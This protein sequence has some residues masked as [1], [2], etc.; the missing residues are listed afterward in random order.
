MSISSSLNA[1]VMGLNSNSSRLSAISDNIAN[2]ST[3][4]YKRSQ[5]DFSSMVLQQQSSAYAAG[6]VRVS[7]FKDI[8][9]TGSLISTGNATDLA[10]SGRGLV[11]V[12]DNT[13]VNSLSSER[14]LMLL[15]TGSFYADES[16]NL[17][18]QS[19]L[20]LLGWPAN[21]DGEIGNVSRNSGSNL[22][23]VNIAASQYTASP[24]SRIELGINLPADATTAGGTG[25]SYTL[26][27][28]YFD[29]L[30]R[31]QTLS[32]EFTP[33]VPASGSSN[34]WSVQIF[35]SAGDPAV[36]I[37]DLDITFADSAANG[38]RIDTLTASGGAVYDSS[39]GSITLNLPHG[40]VDVFMGRPSDS[41]GIT[42][43]S[44]NFSP[45]SVSKDGAPIGDLQSVEI[46]ENGYL[47]AI[48][49]TGFRR[50]LYQI[51]VGDVPNMN[52][53]KALDGQAFRVSAESGNLYL[54]DAGT[55][56]VGSIEGYALME[57]TT[58][59]AAELTDL[60]ETQRAY[61]SSAKI[62]QT[63]DEMLQETT[64][65]KR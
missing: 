26:P 17:R 28:E 5:V 24:T 27:I 43:L 6:G 31:A 14:S 18:T 63:V 53:L 38:G 22:E 21:S 42:Q 60:I 4:G 35:D 9:A 59:I 37:G 33:T 55:G 52:G 51:P 40:P 11:P 16:G 50:T 58:D 2:S 57:S 65:L 34:A 56:P 7:A 13:G 49:N 36:S 30:G 12:T 8:S 47:Q 10:V 45:T 48:Y 64:N 54:W 3:Y 19:G 62:V 25:E 61:S 41:A 46:D 44:A 23:P 1:G 20:F 32:I 29:N 15:P 39:T